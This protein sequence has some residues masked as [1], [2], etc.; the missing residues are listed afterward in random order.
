MRHGSLADAVLEVGE[1]RFVARVTSL[2][3]PGCQLTLPAHRDG[4]LFRLA[5]A[6][7]L[8]RDGARSG[9]AFAFMQETLGLSSQRIADLFGVDRKTVHR[10]RQRPRVGALE[11]S[12]LGALV[13]DAH[14]GRTDTR[15]R[16]VRLRGGGPAVEEMTQVDLVP[17]RTRDGRP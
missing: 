6:A 3:C 2:V 13:L 12:V 7:R 16:L 4:R 10:W 14:L 1:R 11:M 15:D 9:A 5:V 17:R 8:A